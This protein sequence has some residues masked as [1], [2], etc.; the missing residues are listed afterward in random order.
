MKYRLGLINFK[1]R[2]AW[3]ETGVIM[4]IKFLKIFYP[5]NEKDPDIFVEYSNLIFFFTDLNFT[6][7]LKLNKK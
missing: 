5:G 4:R 1:F 2:H 7:I 3:F 6:K